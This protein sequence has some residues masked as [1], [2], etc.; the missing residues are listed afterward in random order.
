MLRRETSN[1][2]GDMRKGSITF[3]LQMQNSWGQAH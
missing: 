1:V 2:V 3:V